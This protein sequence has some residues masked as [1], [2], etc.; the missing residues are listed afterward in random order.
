M[1]GVV[2]IKSKNE[3][4]VPQIE[5]QA[6][7]SDN[8]EE[9]SKTAA[10]EIPLTKTQLKKKNKLEKIMKIRIEKRKKEREAKKLKRVLKKQNLEENTNEIVVSRKALKK[11]VMSN[12]SN[13]LRIVID[14]S[15][16][17]LMQVNN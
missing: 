5:I 3:N 4:I 15:F 16:E 14:C 11:N 10:N 8:N 2:E 12:S 6:E 7:I 13:K 17:N 1:T 9:L